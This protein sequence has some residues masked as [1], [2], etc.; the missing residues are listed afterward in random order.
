M[1][2]LH[3]YLREYVDQLETL[4][5]QCE[6]GNDACLLQAAHRL[7][8]EEDYRYLVLTAS[9]HALKRGVEPAPKPTES[10]NDFQQAADKVK[11]KIQVN[12]P[13]NHE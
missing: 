5:K 1:S 6:P 7:W 11:G 10:E 13:V 4:L 2:D 9:Q 8:G 3:S 12:K